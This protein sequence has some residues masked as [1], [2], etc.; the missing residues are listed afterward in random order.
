[1]PDDGMVT[2]AMG[3]KVYVHPDDAPAATVTPPPSLKVAPPPP[4]ADPPSK[5]EPSPADL[6]LAQSR[7]IVAA[8]KFTRKVDKKDP[9]CETIEIRRRALHPIGDPGATST[10]TGDEAIMELTGFCVGFLQAIGF[11]PTEMPFDADDDIPEDA[12]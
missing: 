5:P 12:S 3:D 1:M 10:V 7:A 9:Y 8:A 4:K 2:S 6:A 11:L